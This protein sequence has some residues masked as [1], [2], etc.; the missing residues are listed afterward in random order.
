MIT[1][2]KL[3]YSIWMSYFKRFC[4]I[5]FKCIGSQTFNPSSPFCTSL[6]VVVSQTE[7]TLC[8]AF[9]RSKC[10]LTIITQ[11]SKMVM[12]CYKLS[13]LTVVEQLSMA[14]YIV[15]SWL[16][17]F[18]PDYFKEESSYSYLMSVTISFICILKFCSGPFLNNIIKTK[19]L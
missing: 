3:I 14:I 11:S 13:W 18:C 4:R 2:S 6:L 1:F 10:H 17:N 19:R 9:T 16:F 5:G 15:L 8:L 12:Y 7:S